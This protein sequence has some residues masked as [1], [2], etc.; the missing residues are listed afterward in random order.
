[1]WRS[2]PSRTAG[3]SRCSTASTS[4]RPGRDRGAHRPQRLRQEHAPADRSAAC[5]PPDRGS[6]ELAGEPVDWTGRRRRV[7][8][9]GTAA[10]AV[11]RRRSRNVGFPLELAGWPEPRRQARASELLD[12]VGLRGF[13]RARPHELSGGMRQRV[14]IARALAL[15]PSVLLLDEPFSALDAL[16]RDRFNAEL[17]ATSGRATGRYDRARDPQHRRGD[18]PRRSRRRPV[19]PPGAHRGRP[20]GRPAPPARPAGARR[21]GRRT[22]SVATIRGHLADERDADA[23]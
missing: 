19:A 3:S 16:T 7:R 6:V 20:S 9:P 15:E 22:S 1:M 21:A 5:S 13:A 23:R 8:L 4:R 12:L 18:L 11:A 2:F 17:A 10:A 14:A